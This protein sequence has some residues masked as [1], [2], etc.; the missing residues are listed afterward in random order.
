MT[1][2]SY[3][4]FCG[5]AKALDI[6]GERWTL[7]VVRNLL[8]GPQRY[9]ELLQGLPGITTNLLAKRLKTMGH[10]GLIEKTRDGHAY[11]LTTLGAGLEPAVHALGRWGWH[12]MGAPARGDYRSFDYLAV[13]L[14]RR[15]RKNA[16]LRAEI[17]A[18]GLPY[19]LVL[20][21]TRVQIE[22]GDMPS[23]DVRLIGPG[24][25]LAQIFL[26]EQVR[27]RL[28]RDVRAEGSP[29]AIRTLLSAFAP[30]DTEASAT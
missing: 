5:L 16:T 2:R 27:K 1:G 4:Q 8:L 3:Q 15:Y 26:A 6:V 17:I 14:R 19:R 11:Q 10:L 21:P 12:R 7:L 29:T 9:S 28:P 30:A 13:A 22:R 25:S 24:A 18:D 20:S 23:A